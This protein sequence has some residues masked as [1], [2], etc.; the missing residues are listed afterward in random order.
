MHIQWGE[1]C[2]FQE[3]VATHKIIYTLMYETQDES[4]NSTINTINRTVHVTTQ[5]TQ[6]TKQQVEH[7][8]TKHQGEEVAP[9]QT[10]YKCC[11]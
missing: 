5:F 7:T 10:H 11:M 9:L 4:E 8:D 2:C 3:C 6:Y 1:K